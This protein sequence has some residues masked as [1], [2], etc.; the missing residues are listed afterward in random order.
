MLSCGT[1]WLQWEFLARKVYSC[2]NSKWWQT[3]RENVRVRPW[4]DLIAFSASLDQERSFFVSFK[5]FCFC[6]C[7]W[8]WQH[9]L[10]LCS[11]ALSHQADTFSICVCKGVDSPGWT[12]DRHF[13]WCHLVMSTLSS[14]QFQCQKLCQSQCNLQSDFQFSVVFCFCKLRRISEFHRSYFPNILASHFIYQ[15][16]SWHCVET[17]VSWLPQL[18]KIVSE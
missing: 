14:V 9:H 12:G 11:G 17:Q 13:I 8:Y 7:H 18:L 16:Y 6:V 5:L 15:K 3:P 2:S 4:S 10:A 1:C